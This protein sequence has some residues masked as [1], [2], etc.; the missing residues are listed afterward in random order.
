MSSAGLCASQVRLAVRDQPAAR[1]MSAVV[2]KRMRVVFR[3][4]E[5]SIR[6]DTH[7]P[8]LN[9]YPDRRPRLRRFAEQLWGVSMTAA[10]LRVILLRAILETPVERHRSE[11]R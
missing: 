9:H 7:E 4:D 2:R 5:N 11:V 6:A 1:R 10:N 8:R 3:D